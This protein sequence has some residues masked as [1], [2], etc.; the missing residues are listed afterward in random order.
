MALPTRYRLKSKKDFELVKGEGELIRTP[1]FSI[2]VLKG[3]RKDGPKVGLIVS[4]KIDQRAVVRNKIRRLL[5]RA[6]VGFLPKMDQNLKIIILAKHPLK[7]ANFDQVK[8][9]FADKSEL[10]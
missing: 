7:E 8:R 10:F 9:L 1:L 3:D 2:L 4:K 5:S 6:I